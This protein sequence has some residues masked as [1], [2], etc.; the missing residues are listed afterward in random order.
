M[1]RA[2]DWVRFMAQ[3]GEWDV[4]MEGYGLERDVAEEERISA[5]RS[6]MKCTALY[7][8]RRV[9]RVEQGRRLGGLTNW[10]REMR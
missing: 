4:N 1:R 6:T 2:N 3:V 5:T 9:G 8:E 7:R 10:S